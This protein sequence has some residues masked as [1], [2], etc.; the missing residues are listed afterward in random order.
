MATAA[1][2]RRTA[3]GWAKTQAS[4]ARVSPAVRTMPPVIPSSAR[5]TRPLGWGGRAAGAEGGRLRAAGRLWLRRAAGGQQ[6][7]THLTTA[8]TTPLARGSPHAAGLSAPIAGLAARHGRA[9]RLFTKASSTP[10]ATDA[11]QMAEHFD[12]TGFTLESTVAQE[13]TFFS[14]LPLDRAAHIR[15]DGSRL[16]ELWASPQARL[17]PILG[18]GMA[19]AL[20]AT[21]GAEVTPI[22]LKPAACAAQ[23]IGKALEQSIF[24]GH[25]EKG[26]PVFAVGISSTSGDVIA[27]AGA[28]WI[29]VRQAGTSLPEAMAAVLAYAIGMV[30][31][32]RAN[33]FCC[34][35]GSRTAPSK[36]GHVR[37]C[38]SDDR[39][40]RSVYP[41]IDPAAIM[42]I[43]CGDFAL[44]G[45]SKRWKPGRYSCL[46]GFLEI[47]ETLELNVVREVKE[48]T[49][50]AV[51]VGSVRYHSS[52]PWP[53][54]R[55]L[56]VGFRGNG[57][58]VAH[59][60]PGCRVTP[61][62]AE[63]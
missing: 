41:R 54:P 27:E 15:S 55:S 31:W 60:M 57:A 33:K 29:D 48:E 34:H 30:A 24:L 2:L 49:G 7:A 56:M 61:I 38:T 19:P 37:R 5:P 36:G 20:E 17:V 10:P 46:A 40:C 1:G 26:E 22:M 35:C 6:G 47:G 4:C 44:L 21:P 43:T 25:D 58:G 13:G 16:Q 42:L 3:A 11:A 59:G 39:G 8:G 28:S 52:Q 23:L 12:S 18:G 50:V 53:F 14:N 45:R 32:N 9:I 51:D 62:P 63:P